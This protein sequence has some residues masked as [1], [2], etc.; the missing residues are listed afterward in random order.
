MSG[1]PQGPAPNRFLEPGTRVIIKTTCGPRECVIHEGPLPFLAHL[2]EW[3]YVR[4]PD[5]PVPAEAPTRTRRS[6]HGEKVP[7]DTMTFVVG[8]HNRDS[9]T[10]I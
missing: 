1:E 4:D 10:V 2:G 3:Y 6:H 9:L 7:V 5:E 8:L